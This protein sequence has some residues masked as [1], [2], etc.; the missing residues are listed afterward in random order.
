M[1][2][3]RRKRRLL[4]ALLTGG[5]L[6]LSGGIWLYRWKNPRVAAGFRAPEGTELLLVINTHRFI[7]DALLNGLKIKGDTGLIRSKIRQSGVDISSPFWVFASNSRNFAGACLPIQDAK[8]LRTFLKEALGLSEMQ[9]E[10]GRWTGASMQALIAGDMLY[11]YLRGYAAPADGQ[12]LQ[13]G[14]GGYLEAGL[15]DTLFRGVVAGHHPVFSSLTANK[16]VRFTAT[17]SA[18]MLQLQFNRPVGGQPH[19]DTSAAV[20]FSLPQALLTALPGSRAGML[21]HV[22]RQGLDTS[23]IWSDNGNFSLRIG[24]TVKTIKTRIVTY[25]YDEEFN[26]KEFVSYREKNVPDAEIAWQPETDA[27]YRRSSSDSQSAL[28]KARSI[29]AYPVIFT[30]GGKLMTAGKNNKTGLQRAVPGMLH[31]HIPGVKQAVATFN[32]PKIIPEGLWLHQADWVNTP[33]GSVFTIQMRSGD[34][35]PAW[36]KL[37]EDLRHLK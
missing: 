17:G 35:R 4:I 10:P 1:T 30:A 21:R 15:S 33:Q 7:E 8:K 18:D 16:D 29:F 28:F 27:W 22:Y 6:L 13:T 36:M 31:I 14:H 32:F 20:A 3:N 26:R 34:K 12:P 9:Q 5:L 19:I 11:L 24:R 37:L 23:G 25:G 2:V